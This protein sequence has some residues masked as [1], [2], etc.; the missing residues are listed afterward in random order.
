M[1]IRERWST[2][3]PGTG[4]LI[5]LLCVFVPL[6]AVLLRPFI[7]GL[8]PS[9]PPHPVAAEFRLVS[10]DG[11]PPSKIACRS[12]RP[13]GR[14]IL[15]TNGEWWLRVVDCRL[16]YG[17][18]T[19]GGTYRWSGDTLTLHRKAARRGEFPLHILVLRGDTLDFSGRSGRKKSI[20]RY[21]RVHT[22]RP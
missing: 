14:L 6:T 17:M 1:R 20:S 22:P 16:R 5:L 21:V 18:M 4:R 12:R 11:K 3:T 15:G 19:N 9:R 13:G 2:R 8:K 7:E 10:V